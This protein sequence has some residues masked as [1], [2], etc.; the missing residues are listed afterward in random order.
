MK[1]VDSIKLSEIM[2]KSERTSK[3]DIKALAENIKTY[4]VQHPLLITGSGNGDHPYEIIDGRRRFEALKLLGAEKAPCLVLTR[5]EANEDLSLIL[6]TYRLN[7]NPV[8][9]YNMA[10][11]YVK[12]ELKGDPLALPPERIKEVATKL[13]LD[14]NATCRILNIGRLDKDTMELLAAGKIPL[15]LALLSL[16]IPEIKSRQ[17]FCKR[18]AKERPS[19]REAVSWL[20]FGEKEKACRDLDN[21]IFDT[22]ECKSCR[23]RGQRDKSLFEYD[24]KE[25]EKYCWNVNC[26]NKKENEVWNAAFKEVRKKLGLSRISKSN[27]W[28]D[29]VEF[30][31]VIPEDP[32]KCKKCKKVKLLSMHGEGFIVKCPVECSNIKKAKRSDRKQKKDPSKFTKK[33]KVQ[34]LEERFALAARKAMVEDILLIKK[35]GDY[36]TND[37]SFAKGKTPKDYKRILFFVGCF[38]HRN[39]FP[40]FYVRSDYSGENEKATELVKSL[41]LKKV[42]KEN[43][44]EAARYLSTY[45]MSGTTPEQ[46]DMAISLLYGEE[47]WCKT[48]Y[49]SI[50]TKLSKRSKGFLKDVKP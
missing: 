16:R 35:G 34:I 6:N 4:G 2:F 13:N 48:H 38:D 43:I 20:K 50:E 10:A 18:C 46:I 15:G 23:H 7:L 33:D 28:F 9:L 31:K 44:P 22:K 1:Q 8:E 11:R 5:A 17:R 41:D 19:I 25:E 30:N 24:G 40:A 45:D 37:I 39:P 32:E 26:Y 42:A 29:S 27:N 14:I 47:N 3:G 36:T 49:A 12:D 21:A